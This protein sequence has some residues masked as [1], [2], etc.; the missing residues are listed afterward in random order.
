[1]TKP[2]VHFLGDAEFFKFD[3][4]FGVVEVA[5][6]YGVDHPRLGRD[7]IRTSDVVKKNDDGSFETLNTLYVPTKEER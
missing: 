5:R 1:M 2:T 6:V 3:T 4:D 7:W